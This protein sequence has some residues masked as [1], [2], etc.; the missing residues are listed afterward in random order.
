MKKGKLIIIFLIIVMSAAVFVGCSND[1]YNL[2]GSAI[3]NIALD[4][5]YAGAEVSCP[6][7][8]ITKVDAKNYKIELKNL[9]KIT[10]FVFCEGFEVEQISLSSAQ[11]K[12]GVIDKTVTLAK[13]SF[14]TE[15]NISGPK[16]DDIVVADESV[17]KV[18]KTK[19]SLLLYS[20]EKLTKLKISASGFLSYD[21][22]VELSYVNYKTKVELE[23]LKENDSKV[24]F[25]IK[26]DVPYIY[27]YEER[28]LVFSDPF[29]SDIIFSETRFNSSA[30]YKTIVLDNN[31]RCAVSV[32]NSTQG[33]RCFDTAKLN[34][35]YTFYNLSDFYQA[36][37]STSKTE[38]E[39]EGF[40]RDDPS[41]GFRD[42]IYIKN[43]APVQIEMRLENEIESE[44]VR[45]DF[46]L[47]DELTIF[48]GRYNP[49]TGRWEQCFYKC[50]ITEDI[51]QSKKIVFDKHFEKFNLA[52]KD[53][54]FNFS[55]IFEVDKLIKEDIDCS[56]TFNGATTNATAVNGE[57]V[58][59]NFAYDE[60]TINSVEIR[61]K[62]S[63]YKICDNGTEDYAWFALDDFLR[64]TKTI[65]LQPN[66][67]YLVKFKDNNT[68]I[69]GLYIQK[70]GMH[71]D[72]ITQTEV[73][74][75]YYERI[76]SANADGYLDVTSTTNIFSGSWQNSHLIVSVDGDGN[77]VKD[78]NGYTQ[79][80]SFDTNY[81]RFNMN[82]NP[83]LFDQQGV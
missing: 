18:E 68:Y 70:Y 57:Y 80:E 69:K 63:K 62:S 47:G 54:K 50:V 44:V 60:T 35:P 6:E 43:K 72:E 46:E 59:K 36:N 25:I 2:N 41:G 65:S 13:R 8:V 24:A 37:V 7:G 40:G 26:N 31:K 22:P 10:I 48:N 66:N 33:A 71:I 11:L 27:E 77:V 79:Y 78:A 23:M 32:D 1:N 16:L 4:Q 51:L 29:Y 12:A 28:R 42:S 15:L 82:F 5:E 74:G 83:L 21:F 76:A 75:E 20:A 30:N 45:A 19:N 39:L 73:N 38:F 3:V 53:I 14:V 52:P 55:N 67:Q 9:K 61:I 49:Q 17:V 81:K 56:I 64:G 34:V 58:F